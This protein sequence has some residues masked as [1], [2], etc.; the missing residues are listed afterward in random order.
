MSGGPDAHHAVLSPL[1]TGRRP[2]GKN[3]SFLI[4]GSGSDTIGEVG[5]EA[6]PEVGGTSSKR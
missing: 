6:R 5:R 1:T 3:F 4:A 2:G